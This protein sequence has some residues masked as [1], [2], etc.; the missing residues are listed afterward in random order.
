MKRWLSALA[1][2]LLSLLLLTTVFADATTAQRFIVAIMAGF[3]V[4]AIAEILPED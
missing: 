4:S 3:T 1:A 2:L